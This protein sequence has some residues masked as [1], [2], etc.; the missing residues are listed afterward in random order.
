MKFTVNQ[1]DFAEALN[2]ASKAIVSKTALDI[3]KGFYVEAYDHSLIVMGNNLEVGIRTKVDALIEKEGKSVIDAKVISDIIRKLPN[4]PINV[5]VKNGTV[6]IQCLK[7]KFTIKEMMDNGYPTVEE[8]EEA[9]YQSIDSN[10]LYEMIR[11]TNFAVSIDETK[12]V[13]MGELLELDGNQI[14]LVALDG[15]RLAYKK[16]EIH[17][18]VGYQKILIP[19]KTM[20][21]I[22]KLAQNINEDIKIGIEERHASFVFGNTLVNTQLIQGE[23]AKYQEIIPSEFMTT[24]KIDRQ[25]F[26]NSLD[27]ASLV[28]NNYLVKLKIQDDELLITAHDKEVGNLEE[29]VDVEM[30]G[31]DL[32]IAFNIRYFMEALKVIEDEKIYLKFNSNVSPCVIKP[33]TEENYTYLLLPVRI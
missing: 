14:N 5:E 28:S 30:E 24:I 4:A 3:L 10:I 16:C 23:F 26:I 18:S 32:E 25:E 29:I 33:E 2:I 11:K 9:V 13:F 12:P 6:L 19:G 31:R 7:S 15:Y 21:E 22:M 8:L 20:S 17:S 1:R 27:R